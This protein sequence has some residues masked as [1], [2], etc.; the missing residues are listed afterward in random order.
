[1]MS[2]SLLYLLALAASA[3]D[4][5]NSGLSNV[6]KFEPEVDET[7]IPETVARKPKFCNNLDCPAFKVIA[8]TVRRH[9]LYT[10]GISICQTFEDNSGE[11]L[12]N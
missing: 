8:K 4:H 5:W 1:M 3:S 2:L 9:L 11:K 12:N 6:F 10:F 7:F